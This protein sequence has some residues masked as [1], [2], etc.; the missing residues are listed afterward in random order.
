MKLTIGK[1]VIPQ[2]AIALVA[3]FSTANAQQPAGKL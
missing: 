3:N 1:I 2:L